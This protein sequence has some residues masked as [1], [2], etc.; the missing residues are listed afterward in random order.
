MNNKYKT[1]YNYLKNM[2]HFPFCICSH[3]LKKLNILYLFATYTVAL[4]HKKL[5]IV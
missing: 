4:W 3:F 2:P 1:E 5:K